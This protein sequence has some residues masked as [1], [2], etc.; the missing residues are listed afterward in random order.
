MLFWGAVI[1]G[2]RWK[3][4]VAHGEGD[5]KGHKVRFCHLYRR[6]ITGVS[7]ASSEPGGERE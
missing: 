1:S 3:V 5:G 7:K 6:V 2:V 4:F